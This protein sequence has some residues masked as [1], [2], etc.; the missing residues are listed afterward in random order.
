ME[1]LFKLLKIILNGN[2]FNDSNMIISNTVN[3]SSNFSN[4]VQI[5]RGNID[6][7]KQ[8]TDTDSLIVDIVATDTS[9]NTVTQQDSLA[10]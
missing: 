2:F 4:V 5:S 10:L 3:S 1:P 7:I 6:L 9:G 8:Y